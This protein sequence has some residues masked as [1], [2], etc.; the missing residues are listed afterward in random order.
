MYTC[1]PTLTIMLQSFY[2]PINPYTLLPTNQLGLSL[3]SGLP[4]TYCLRAAVQLAPPRRGDC[5][6][7]AQ[8]T[9]SRD[10]L[11]TPAGFFVA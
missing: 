10:F 2:F 4:L 5:V 7:V 3:L 9:V 1:V 11:F 6:A 8:R